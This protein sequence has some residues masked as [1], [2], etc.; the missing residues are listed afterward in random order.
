MAGI[1]AFGP[2]IVLPWLGFTG[3]AE[4]YWADTDLVGPKEK[5]TQ[6]STPVK[7]TT[8]ARYLLTRLVSSPDPAK[9]V[10]RREHK[11]A[12]TRTRG[13]RMQALAV[14]GFNFPGGSHG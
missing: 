13:K 4:G 9:C 12:K 8:S 3:D 2:P 6:I 5:A 1:L 11:T 7:T 10:V 14:N